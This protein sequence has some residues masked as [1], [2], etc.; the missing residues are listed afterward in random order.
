[1]PFRYTPGGERTSPK[2]VAPHQPRLDWQMWFA[3]LGNYRYNDWALHLMYKILT[4]PSTDRLQGNQLLEAVPFLQLLD[5]SKYPFASHPPKEVRVLL[6]HYD[7]TRLNTTWNRQVP[8]TVLLGDET[9]PSQWERSN[10]TLK[11]TLPNSQFHILSDTTS[12]LLF[13]NGFHLLLQ[14]TSRRRL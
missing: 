8:G 13:A 4:A 3:A 14:K 10:R 5:H 2:R 7:F 9:S 6:Y 11:Q 1:M 12:V